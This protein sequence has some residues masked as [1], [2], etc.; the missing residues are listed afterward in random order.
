MESIN[1]RG[2]EGLLRVLSNLYNIMQ[3]EGRF[4]CTGADF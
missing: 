1:I 2:S 4:V 3:L